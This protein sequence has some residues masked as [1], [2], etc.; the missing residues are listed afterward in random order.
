LSHGSLARRL[1]AA[2]AKHGLHVTVR[3]V[4]EPNRLEA[5]LVM[6]VP[7]LGALD[8]QPLRWRVRYSLRARGLLRRSRGAA[9]VVLVNTQSCALLSHGVMRR[10]PVVISVDATGRQFAA[11]Q[12]W[13][14][15]TRADRLSELPVDA[16]ERRAYAGAR[17]IV[18]W[19]EWTAR[20]LREEYGV[21]AERIR[22]LHLGVDVPA[23]HAAGPAVEHDGRLRVLFVGNGVERKGLPTLMRAREL[24]RA[25][26]DLDVVTGDPV[27]EASGVTV[28]RGL[29]AGSAALARLYATA[30][31]FV[32]PTRADGVPWVVAEAMAAGL[33]VVAGAVGAIPEMLGDAGMLV[34]PGDAVALAGALDRL[35]GSPAL[36]TDLGV[37]AHRRARER[38]DE[39]V[40]I[41]QLSAVLREAAST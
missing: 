38:F 20:S 10:M 22:V 39:A 35:A 25:A 3:L 9:D 2:L 7:R 4:P 21:P 18:A 19:T 28:H 36:R 16:L 11:L 27:E 26:I 40:Q 6:F 34:E 5:R 23:A 29:E 12:Y 24:T 37:R 14:P 1:A 30:Q 13:R 33:P 32:L 17:T 15:R 8:F 31:A 41:R